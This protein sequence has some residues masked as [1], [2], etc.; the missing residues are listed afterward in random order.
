MLSITYRS[1]TVFI[2]VLYFLFG[3]NSLA[4]EYDPIS[5]EDKVLLDKSNNHD[6]SK[7]EREQFGIRLLAKAKKNKDTT[8]LVEVNFSLAVIRYEQGEFIMAI[9]NL[10]DMFESQY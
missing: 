8:L 7:S 10:N 9:H 4:Q 1:V 6:Y 5:K 3:Q 2:I